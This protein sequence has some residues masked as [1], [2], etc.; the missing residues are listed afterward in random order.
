MKVFVDKGAIGATTLKKI[1]DG[2]YEVWFEGPY[3]A[4]ITTE[5]EDDED[6][7]LDFDR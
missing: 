1:P 4:Q 3:E 6:E 7:H 5:F 2:N